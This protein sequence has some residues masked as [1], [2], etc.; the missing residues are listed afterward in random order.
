MQ[1]FVLPVLVPESADRWNGS[2]SVTCFC[3]RVKRQVK[4]KSFYYLFLFNNQKTCKLQDF[5]LPV[6]VHFHVGQV[7]D[8][9]LFHILLLGELICL[10]WNQNRCQ[11]KAPQKT[12]PRSGLSGPWKPCQNGRWEKSLYHNWTDN[13]TDTP[14]YRDLMIYHAASWNRFPEQ[15]CDRYRRTP[16]KWSFWWQTTPLLKPLS[17][18]FQGSLKGGVVKTFPPSKMCEKLWKQNIYLSW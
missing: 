14:S 3:S 10:L 16:D 4:W 18:G 8:L 13:W 5:L 6:L 1:D 2:V 12:S 9:P 7:T 11:W 17:A 15:H